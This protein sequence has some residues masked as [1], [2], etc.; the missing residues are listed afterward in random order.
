[1]L[2][3][4]TRESLPGF[5][6]PEEWRGLLSVSGSV[7][8]L[9]GDDTGAVLLYARVSGPDV[10]V[11]DDLGELLSSVDP[12]PDLSPEG[13]SFLLHD[14][15][16]PF[17]RTVYRD[18]FCL[19]VGDRS[20]LRLGAGSVRTSFSV[21][22]P[23]SS[24]RS[25]EDQIPDT[26]RLL[27]LLAEATARRLEPFDEAALLLSAGKD[28]T[29]LALALAE[30]GRTDVRCLTYTSEGDDEHV[31]AGETCRRLGLR[32]EVVSLDG[33]GVSVPDALMTF[34]ERSPLPPGDLAQIPVVVLAAAA[35][36]S[37]ECLLEGTGNDATFGYV[38]RPKDAR[39]ARFCMG[40]WGWVDGLKR[41]LPVDS[42]LNYAL[43]DPVEINWPGLRLRYVDSSRLLAG[44]VNTSR[45]W[46]RV[47]RELRGLDVTDMRT[48]LRGRHFEIGAQRQKI[49]LAARAFGVI[50]LYPYQDPAVI[51]YYFNLPERDR[52]DRAGLVNKVL[53][54]RL[55]RERLDYDPAAIG[56]RGFQ[57][58]GAGF[59]ARYRDLIVEEIRTCDLFY[60]RG[61]DFLPDSLK[62][63]NRT[64]FGWHHVVGLFQLAAWYNHTQY[65]R[66]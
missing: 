61:L 44:A 7:I 42:E 1:M 62:R 27:S 57:F 41:L 60:D 9:R 51:D 46:R 59:V 5:E 18:I 56:K 21:D 55:L 30:C 58:D 31:H 39:A 47:R 16:V 40:R 32:H 20:E 19:T 65:L 63:V 12:P 34:F 37:L 2:L 38:P 3:H 15:Q 36:A 49:D 14:G 45:S 23:Y 6:V 52:F 4:L 13:L 24:E 11:S 54:R 48:L 10:T 28:S 35:G 64:R 25:R 17:P 43:R 26:G 33:A 29:A 50:P 8:A 53:L 22:F 66:R